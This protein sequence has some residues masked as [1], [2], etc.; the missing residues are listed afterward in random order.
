[1]KTIKNKIAVTFTLSKLEIQFLNE[2]A[3][4]TGVSKSVILGNLILNCSVSK[5]KKDL[6]KQFKDGFLP[7]QKF[8]LEIKNKQV[9]KTETLD[10]IIQLNKRRKSFNI[11]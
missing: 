11:K 1:M 2:Y 9:K 8:E 10:Q 7:H 5:L 6:K 4:L 3:L